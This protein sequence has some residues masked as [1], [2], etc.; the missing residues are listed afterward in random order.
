MVTHVEE[1]QACWRYGCRSSADAWPYREGGELTNEGGFP[2]QPMSMTACGA[3][4]RAAADQ[5]GIYTRGGAAGALADA[6]GAL[7]TPKVICKKHGR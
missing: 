7:E 3:E 5:F 2:A 1:C 4:S 6:A